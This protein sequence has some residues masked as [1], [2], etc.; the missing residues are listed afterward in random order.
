MVVVICSNENVKDAPAFVGSDP[1]T[2]MV[3]AA[4][5]FKEGNALTTV[6][7]ALVL[8]IGVQDSHRGNCDAPLCMSRL[9]RRQG[10]GIFLLIHVIKRCIYYNIEAGKF[11]YVTQVYPTPVDLYLQC[12][13]SYAYHFYLSAGFIHV[14]NMHSDGWEFLPICLQDALRESPQSFIKYVPTDGHPPCKLMHLRPGCLQLPTNE[15]TPTWQLQME[16]KQILTQV[17]EMKEKTNTE[18]L[19]QTYIWCRYPSA[20]RGLYEKGCL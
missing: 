11:G 1:K 3:I 20:R 8:W 18:V 6:R 17:K 15:T 14:N 5:T 7:P 16:E 10:F 13:T 19:A 9:W 2:L 12:T 4:V